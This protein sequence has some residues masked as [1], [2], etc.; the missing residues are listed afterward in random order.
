MAQ[1]NDQVL[2]RVRKEL[3]DKPDL[4]SRELFTMAQEMDE[5]IGEQSMQQFHA[6]YVLPIK[7][8]QSRARG[9]GA[10]KRGGKPKRARRA[11]A[12]AK[13]ASGEVGSKRARSTAE[14]SDRDRVRGVLLEFARDFAGAESRSDIVKVLSRVDEYVDRIVPA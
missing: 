10:S 1:R 14:S 5:T 9:G 13:P 4:G 11:A 7:R 8:E 6:R 12:A 2:D 3:T